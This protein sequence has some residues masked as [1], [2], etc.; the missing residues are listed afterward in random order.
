VRLFEVASQSVW[1]VFAA[2]SP[3]EVRRAGDIAVG[4]AVAVTSKPLLTNCHVI[5]GRPLVWIKQ[6]DKVERA[7]VSFGDSQSDRCILSVEPDV[8]VAVRGMR[9]YDDLKVGEEVYTIG[10]PSGLEA[11][12]GQGVISGLRRLERRRL[13]QS[14]APISPGSSGGGLFDKSGNLIGVTSFRLREGQNLNF[15]ISVEDYFQ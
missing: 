14:S 10:S 5:E 6:G 11:T 1:L 3:E 4:S 8:L 2:R 13:L 15:A 9:G 7:R 12:L